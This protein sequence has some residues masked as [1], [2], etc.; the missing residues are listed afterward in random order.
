MCRVRSAATPMKISGEAMS[1]VPA[2]WCSPIHASSQPSRS[3]CWTSSRSRSRASVGFSPAWWNGAMKMPKRRRSVMLAHSV[4]RYRSGAADAA[5]GRT[6]RR[7]ASGRPARRRPRRRPS[8]RRPSRRRCRPPARG[9]A[10]PRAP[11]DP[12]AMP[13]GATRRCPDSV[14]TV[15]GS[16]NRIRR[17]APSPPRHRPAPP[18]PAPDRELL[19]EHREPPLEH[20]GIGQ[21]GVGHVGLH[22]GRA[23]EPVARARA[24]A[25]VS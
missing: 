22:H 21:P 13:Y 3:R 5:S 8:R 15:I 7:R 9:S 6:R 20:L 19:D 10:R 14:L 11:G 23:G 1:S 4:V 2:E 17:T 24:R 12:P 18:L 16:R 25:T